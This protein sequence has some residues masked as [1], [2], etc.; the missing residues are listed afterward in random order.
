MLERIHSSHVG[1]NGCTRRARDVLYWTSMIAEIKAKVGSCAFC[2]EYQVVNSKE[3]LI[4]YDVPTRP[5]QI[6]GTDILSFNDNDS[7]ITAD[8]FSGYFEND[9][10]PSKT[11]CD[12]IYFLKQYFAWHG[13]SDT[14]R[15]NNN[16]FNS[17]KFKVLSANYG[18]EHVTS[19]LVTYYKYRVSCACAL[20]SPIYS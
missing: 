13:I 1:I 7:L 6:V 10:L 17:N 5:W 19:R 3:P 11:A 20:D 9:R 12:V 2:Q 8:Y 16:L 14:M 18:F 15:S 4:T